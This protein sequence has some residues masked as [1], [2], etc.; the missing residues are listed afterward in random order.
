MMDGG[1][2]VMDW[3]TMGGFMWIGMLLWAVL[4]IALIVLVVVGILW[5]AARLRPGAG[6]SEER[7]ALV[8][9]ERRYARGELDRE[10]FLQMRSDLLDRP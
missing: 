3:G 4:V 6:S 1:D 8:E 10:A 9:L 2:H 7:S 5:L